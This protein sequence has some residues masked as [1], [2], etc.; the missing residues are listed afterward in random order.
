MDTKIWNHVMIETYI[1]GLHTHQ[2]KYTLLRQSLPA[3]MI[4][5]SAV[6]IQQGPLQWLK[7]IAL[8]GRLIS[9]QELPEDRY[10]SMLVGFQPVHIRL[11]LQHR[12][13][14]L[15]DV[16]QTV[17]SHGAGKHCELAKVRETL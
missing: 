12:L 7:L 1:K 17:F 14:R 4:L 10:I 6:I 13:L 9:S 3:M 2:I 15:E 16:L 8:K 5:T 11:I